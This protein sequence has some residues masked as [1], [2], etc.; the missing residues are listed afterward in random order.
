MRLSPVDHVFTGV[1]AYPINFLFFYNGKIEA[2]K[3]KTALEKALEFFV[4]AA[5]RLERTEKNTLSFKATS[6]YGWNFQKTSTRPDMTQLEHMSQFFKSAKST[7]GENLLEVTLTHFA[8]TSCLGVSLSHCVV[9]GYSYFMFLGAWS[10]IMRDLKFVPPDLNRE[11]L[12]PTE[13]QSFVL[14]E[15]VIYKATGFDFAPVSR[16]D[17]HS[18]IQWEVLDYSEAQL[19]SLYAETS[20]QSSLRLSLNDVLCAD[21]WKKLVNR[22]QKADQELSFSCAFD[23]RRTFSAIGPLYFGNAVRGASFRMDFDK[24]VTTETAKIAEKIGSTVRSI[25]EG[26]VVSSLQCLEQI[27]L[28][29]GLDSLTRFHVANPHT[30]FLFTNLSRLP[31]LDIDFGVGAPVDFRILTPARRTAVILPLSNGLRVQIAH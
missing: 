9:D 19:K 30:G 12:I 20:Q 5:S 13:I 1:G 3:L 14:S 10:K 26:D 29:Q 2:D 31:L 23:F 21:L 27:R 22:Y 8:E 4:P 28:T 24:V 18:D 16:P 11:K 17:D 6:Q 7:E 25:S 15:D